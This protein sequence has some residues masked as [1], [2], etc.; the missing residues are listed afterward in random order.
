MRYALDAP[1]PAPRAARAPRAALP[2]SSAARE[3]ARRRVVALVL[4]VYLLAIFEGSLRKWVLPQ[5]SQ[6]LYFVRDPVLVWAY[7]V[8]TRHG[9][10]PRGDRWL[11]VALAMGAAGVLLVL[12]Q[13]A[14]GGFSDARLILAVHGFRSY[15]LYVPLAFLIGAQF[16]REDLLRLYRLTLWL[17]IPIAVLVTLQF[18]SPPGAAINVGI[19]ADEEFQFRGLTA[20]AERTRPMGTFSSG[21]G[22]Q[23]FVATAWA[24]ALALFIAPA[25]RRGI[26]LP[27]LLTGA[28]AVMVC[29][30]LSGSRGTVLQ[31]GLAVAF[32]LLVAGIGRSAA[33]KGRA[34]LW[35]G[36]LVGAALLLYPIVLPEGFS[37]LM[38]R[39]TA[40]DKVESRHFDAGVF[41]RALYGLVDFLRLFDSVP[42]LG[43]GLGYGTNASIT[44]KATVDGVMPGLL[45]ETD[46][47]RHMVDLGP[48]FGLAYI[49]FRVALV[50]ALIARALRATRR[51]PDPMPLLLL[52]YVATVVLSGQI[53]GQGAINLYAWLFVGVLL[54]ACR[55]PPVAPRRRAAPPTARHP[56]SPLPQRRILK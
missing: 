8:A 7:V 53:T 24:I 21:A 52:S 55:P 45:A 14:V 1:L 31:C 2:A 17:A 23:Q 50:V 27:V 54:A 36:L 34:L 10:W 5:L 51:A 38:E 18:F 35:T 33:L 6:Y 22:Q 9:L 16:R 25:A 28:A 3:R 42:L 56:D 44:L 40:A 4:A 13:A 30:G 41:G 32:A 39:W 19:S 29:A 46:F 43:Y 49:A 20:T 12:L 47:S 15:F 48:L 26:G 11:A 37:S